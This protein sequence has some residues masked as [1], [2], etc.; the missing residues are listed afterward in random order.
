[1]TKNYIAENKLDVI[2]RA[3]SEFLLLPSVIIFLFIFLSYF[4]YSIDHAK[5]SWLQP[6]RAFLKS[7]IF[8]SSEATSS[9][10]GAIVSGTISVTTLTTTLLLV[11]V[12]QSASS[13]TAQVFDQFLRRKT[14]QFYLGFFVGL[15]LYSMITLATVNDPFNPVLGGTVAFSLTGVALYLLVLLMYTTIDQ[16]RPSEIISAIH[17][18][19]LKARSS[20]MEML[21]FTTQENPHDQQNRQAVVATEGGYLNG[22]NTKQLSTFVQ[23]HCQGS[24]IRFTRSIG[25]F[26]AFHE[27]FAEIIYAEKSHVALLTEELL[28]HTT[29][30]TKRDLDHDT[31]YG[32]QQVETIAW[33]ST[34]TAKSNPSPGILCVHTLHNLLSCWSEEQPTE[35]EACASAI[36]YTDNTLEELMRGFENLAVVSS[37]SMQHQVFE[38]ILT[39]FSATIARVPASW[40]QRIE[41]V[42]LIMLSVMG[43]HVL[44]TALENALETI[45][46]QL[47]GLQR[48]QTA[49]AVEEALQQLK[50][51]VGKLNSRSTRV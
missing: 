29:I 23:T 34:S 8:S 43:D 38:A 14:N 42:L 48:T 16:M 31:T 2:K 22:I 25:S 15:A 33:T 21:A 51:S 9:L 24:R 44:T 46:H 13:M 36:F 27:V 47:Y 6:A 17:S 7:H 10:L 26:I 30:G 40:Q 32:I 12:Q 41:R 39:S 4:T 19:I 5:I 3:F 37:E 35:K 28:K 45:A 50:M 49:R 18:R 11:I 1:M 20:Q